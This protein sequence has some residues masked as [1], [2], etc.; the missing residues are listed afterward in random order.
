MGKIYQN[1]KRVLVWLGRPENRVDAQ[2]SDGLSALRF[3]YQIMLDGNRDPADE[4]NI[5]TLSQSV[6]MVEHWDIWHELAVLCEL[7]YWNRLWI[8]QE[9]GLAS[10]LEV[11]HGDSSIDWKIFADV[12][13]LLAQIV[14]RQLYSERVLPLAKIIL[15]SMP[16][17]LEEQRS[18]QRPFWIKNLRY[19]FSLLTDPGNF[20]IRSAYILFMLFDTA[21]QLSLQERD[22][23]Q[24]EIETDLDE[25][26]NV[27]EYLIFHPDSVPGFLSKTQLPTLEARHG[28]MLGDRAVNWL[29][30]FNVADAIATIPSRLEHVKDHQQKALDEEFSQNIASLR[31]IFGRYWGETSSLAW[32]IP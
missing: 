11:Y 12:R 30:G 15:D 8:I 2:S 28:S 32:G 23:L 9:I 21:S 29:F 24:I 14:Q 19:N 7:P 4:S 17:R 6:Q 3:F 13:Q 25:D 31:S 16:A 26:S 1:A 20:A 22:S 18:Q 5:H 10:D 27:V